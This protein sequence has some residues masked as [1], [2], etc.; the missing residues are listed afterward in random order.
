[1]WECICVYLNH[2]SMSVCIL[3]AVRLHSHVLQH[4]H[5]SP[6]HVVPSPRPFLFSFPRSNA[7]SPQS[8]YLPLYLTCH[9]DLWR[10]DWLQEKVMAIVSKYNITMQRNQT[11][12][13]H[14][15]PSLVDHLVHYSTPV[16]W[17]KQR[18]NKYHHFDLFFIQQGST[19]VCACWHLYSV[20]SRW[21]N[22]ATWHDDCRKW[23]DLKPQGTFKQSYVHTFVFCH[24]WDF[25]FDLYCFYTEL[26]FSVPY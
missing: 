18:V 4:L 6:A 10:K 11:L 16:A 26:I 14:F 15:F 21:H 24:V 13:W 17:K 8:H 2:G 22:R 7:S 19:I 25:S 5:P 3:I 12:K 23:I 1:M 20:I 9:L